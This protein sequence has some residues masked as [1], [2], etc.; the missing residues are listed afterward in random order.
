[1][2][3]LQNRRH[4]FV[5]V[6]LFGGPSDIATSVGEHKRIWQLSNDGGMGKIGEGQSRE[7]CARILNGID[8]WWRSLGQRIGSTRKQD[9]H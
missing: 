2:L 6:F 5:A 9:R 1:M 3:G 4:P 7:A 8:Q